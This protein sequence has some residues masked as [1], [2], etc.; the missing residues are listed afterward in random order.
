[1][2]IAG[3]E[4]RATR[5]LRMVGHT[6]SREN[7]SVTSTKVLSTNSFIETPIVSLRDT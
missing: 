2:A 5:N 6:S 7:I 1:M 3:L 4:S